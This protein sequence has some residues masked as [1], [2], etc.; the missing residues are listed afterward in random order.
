M[1]RCGETEADGDMG[2]D[3]QTEGCGGTWGALGAMGM[4]RDMRG[5]GVT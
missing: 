1:G 3:E 2:E 4:W 5:H